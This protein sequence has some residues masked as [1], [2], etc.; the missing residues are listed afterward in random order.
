M[1]LVVVLPTKLW[2]CEKPGW[3]GNMIG[4]SGARWL[5]PQTLM[6]FGLA[7][8]VPAAEKVEDASPA[9]AIVSPSPSTRSR[10]L[11]GRV[12]GASG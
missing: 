1:A 2:S 11:A 9:D 10:S 4:S 6:K 7:T 12:D 3:P 8:P 5:K